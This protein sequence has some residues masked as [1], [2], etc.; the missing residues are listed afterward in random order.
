VR[1]ISSGNANFQYRVPGLPGQPPAAANVVGAIVADA[2][3]ANAW[4]NFGP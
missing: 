4:A 1:N 2:T 3:T